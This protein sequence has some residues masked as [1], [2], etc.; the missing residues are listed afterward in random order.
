[1]SCIFRRLRRGLRTEIE[2]TN[3]ENIDTV[4]GGYL[5]DRLK[6]FLCLDLHHRHQSVVRLLEVLAK[7]RVRVEALH[8]DRRSEAS[9]TRRREFG[10]LDE[11]P[12][13]F[14]GL[15]ERN[16]DLDG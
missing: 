11:L 16:H 13:L 2:W 9:V 12:R 1:M 3:E 14:Y 10:R 6:G 4:N 7:G 8:C 15:E 5:I